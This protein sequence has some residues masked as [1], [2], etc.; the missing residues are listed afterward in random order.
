M[1]D[2][3]TRA[4]IEHIDQQKSHAE[5]IEDDP[6]RNSLASKPGVNRGCFSR[7]I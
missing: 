6:E 5:S 1:P 2:D 7:A 3:L 4:M